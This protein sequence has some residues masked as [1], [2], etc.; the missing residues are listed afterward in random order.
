[1]SARTTA[2]YGGLIALLLLPLSRD[3]RRRPD[4]QGVIV[5]SK[6]PSLLSWV[7]IVLALATVVWLGWRRAQLR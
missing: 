5:T 1:M 3:I 6:K 4:G 7:V 2:I